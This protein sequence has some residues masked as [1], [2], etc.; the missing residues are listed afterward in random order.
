[1]TGARCSAQVGRQL[2]LGIEVTNGLQVPVTLSRLGAT[3]PMGGLRFVTSAR[4]LGA[5]RTS[6]RRFGAPLPD[7][8]R[9]R[10][11][12]RRGGCCAM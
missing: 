1:M 4:A 8:S 3:F 7:S 10:A 6:C 2:Q 9:L 5:F 12:R 11:T